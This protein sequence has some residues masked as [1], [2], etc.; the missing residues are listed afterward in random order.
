MS[1]PPPNT[2]VVTAEASQILFA[3]RVTISGAGKSSVI[4]ALY[5]LKKIEA[6]VFYDYALTFPTEISE[7]W[8][9]KFSGAQALFFL[10][11]YPYTF[12]TV[13]LCAINLNQNP[14]EM[15]AG[16]LTLRTYAIYQKNVLILVI[17][18]LTS[19]ANIATGGYLEFWAKPEVSS[20]IFGNT[21][22]ANPP[23]NIL[24][25]PQT[26]IC[27]YRLQLVT[28]ILSLLLDV[29]VFTLTFAKTIRHAV[30]MRQAG[31]GNGLGYF[32]LRDGAMYFLAK[33][34]FG[35][36]GV[37]VF[38]LPASGGAVADWVSVLV[39]ISNPLTI[40]L[41][42]R[43]VLNLRQ[44]S[45]LQEGHAS[46][47]DAIITVQE[48]AFAA[49]SLLGNLGAPLRMGTEDDDEIEEIR[50]DDEAE[51]VGEVGIV[52]QSEKLRV[53]KKDVAIDP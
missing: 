3:N 2:A 37:T 16:I 41:V 14:S 28:I 13:F 40:I 44:V 25:T 47:L 21:C 5:M 49:N 27:G 1:D 8:K 19:I 23:S 46:T 24:R 4:F 35:V 10:T 48:P 33:L 15:E 11:R 22:G 50:V 38:F 31:L 42:T 45:R 26:S 34:L 17:L 52:E 9:S 51:A 7:I 30:E 39:G 32:I 6:L 53:T 29:L 12:F 43:L 18:G 20:S 36:L